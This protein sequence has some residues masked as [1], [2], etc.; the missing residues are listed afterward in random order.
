M[1][2]SPKTIGHLAFEL[3]E[4]LPAFV[5]NFI[6]FFNQSQFK[7]TEHEISRQHKAAAVVHHLTTNSLAISISETMILI[8]YKKVLLITK[9]SQDQI[10]N[11]LSNIVEKE[12][13]TSAFRL[14]SNSQKSYIGKVLNNSFKIY[15][16]FKGRNSF[17]P[18]IIGKFETSLI[19]TSISLKMR[20]H[21]I[22]NL[23]LCWFAL[24]VFIPSY[25]LYNLHKDKDALLIGLAIFLF[26]YSVTLYFFQSECRRS[27]TDLKNEFEAD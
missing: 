18:I 1:K 13:W 9:L 26:I 19:G 5:V 17:V 16:L 3:P 23:I 2:T 22:V 6:K 15:R 21:F 10:K 7:L 14:R 20:L 27:I 4:F 25:N 12:S 8:P 24:I 11:R